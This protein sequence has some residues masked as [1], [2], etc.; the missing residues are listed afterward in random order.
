MCHKYRQS[1]IAEDVAGSASED[2]LPH[3][4][5]RVGPLDQEI[6]TQCIRMRQNRLARKAATEIDGQW[7][8]RNA[9]QSQIVAQLLTR[10][11]GYCCSAFDRQYDDTVSPLK[12][13]HRE[14]G[15][16]RLLGA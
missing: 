10:W 6:A 8:C 3:S 15:G 13:R 9:A 12:N 7:F 5:L 1:R 16:A 11:S 4:T 14:S 2:E